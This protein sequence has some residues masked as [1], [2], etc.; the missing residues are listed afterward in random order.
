MGM[1]FDTDYFGA[2]TIDP[3]LG[4]AE[5]EWLRAYAVCPGT[6]GPS[7]PYELAMN[8]RQVGHDPNDPERRKKYGWEGWPPGPMCD[9]EP[10]TCRGFLSWNGQERSNDARDWI[11]YLIDH[12][13]RPGAHA[14]TSG[15]PDFDAFTF[16]HVVYGAVAAGRHDSDRLYLLLVEDNTLRRL[17]VAPG[18][19][20]H[21][22]CKPFVDYGE[23]SQDDPASIDRMHELA[24]LHGVDDSERLRR[25]NAQRPPVRTSRA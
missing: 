13:L 17:T 9:W 3:P 5:T 23:E 15:L 12:F 24:R 11:P 19:W 6:G 1:G 21:P 18:E 10:S 22:D 20:A 2:F 14:S 8:P 16:D 25:R 4:E 7:G